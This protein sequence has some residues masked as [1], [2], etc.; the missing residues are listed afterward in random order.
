MWHLL[1]NV[2]KWCLPLMRKCVWLF[3]L[4]SIHWGLCHCFVELS[5]SEIRN[6]RTWVANAETM[7]CWISRC[8]SVSYQY[9]CQKT[10]K[11]NL[12]SQIM[13]YLQQG[14]CTV[15]VSEF[16]NSFPAKYFSWHEKSLSMDSGAFWH[17]LSYLDLLPRAC[18]QIVLRMGSK[19][20][21]SGI[22]VATICKFLWL[23]L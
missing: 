13:F 5:S 19:K 1:V 3:V 6:F 20:G 7:L 2:E 21:I 14:V 18:V 9:F 15:S 16:F 11:N 23:F 8:Q 4:C 12:A 22:S 10:W 17:F